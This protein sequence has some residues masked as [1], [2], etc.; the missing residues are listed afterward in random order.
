MNRVVGI[1]AQ[2]GKTRFLEGRRVDTPE[3]EVDAAFANLGS[4]RDGGIF[5]G[6]FSGASPWER[7]PNGDELVQVL[8]GSAILS[9]LIDSEQ[10][11]FELS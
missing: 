11:D 1:A 9:I 2:L 7:H 8:Y 6:G 10:Q 5:A 4:Y 3:T